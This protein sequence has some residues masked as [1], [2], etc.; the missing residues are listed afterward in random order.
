MAFA[1]KSH[2]DLQL[3]FSEKTSGSLLFQLN[4]QNMHL[5]LFI[6]RDGPAISDISTKINSR[7]ITRAN[8]NK[9]MEKCKHLPTYQNDI[10]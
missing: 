2:N 3:M 10:R 6:I 1:A 4:G 5:F 8:R 7:P 9:E